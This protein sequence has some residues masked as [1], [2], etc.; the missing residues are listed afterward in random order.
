M[1]FLIFILYDFIKYISKEIQETAIVDECL[2][3]RIY[4][5]IIMTLLKAFVATILIFTLV[6]ISKNSLRT[7]LYGSIRYKG[8]YINHNT[9]WILFR[10]HKFFLYLFLQKQFITRMTQGSVIGWIKL[11]I[12]TTFWRTK[13]V[14]YFRFWSSIKR[15]ESLH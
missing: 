6:L 8:L 10:F 14:Q 13:H 4:T 15:W 5:R 2:N 11:S 9:L 3:L 12:L 1:Q 7:L